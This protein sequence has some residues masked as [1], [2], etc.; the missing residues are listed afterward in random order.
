[1]TQAFMFSVVY[2]N[3]TFYEFI[4]YYFFKNLMKAEIIIE[5]WRK[6]YNGFK[7][8]SASIFKLLHQRLT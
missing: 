4:K 3:K 7:P 2:L 6:E 5:Q 8:H 1:M